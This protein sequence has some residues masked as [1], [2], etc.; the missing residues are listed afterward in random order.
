[1]PTRLLISLALACLCAGA[2]RAAD[3]FATDWAASGK[4]QAR[5]IAGG[6]RQAGFEI[7][8]APGAITYWRNPGDAGAP[9]AFD[10]SGSTNLARAEVRYPAPKRI[11]EP[12][13]SEAFGY[14]DAVVFAIDVEAA[15]PS[16]PVRL[17][18]KAGYAVCEK[19]CLPAK[20]NLALSLPEDGAS[21]YAAPIAAAR[22]LTPKNLAWAALGGEIFALDADN[23]RLCL[24]AEPG[25]ARDLFLEAPSGWW[26]SDKAE[27]KTAGR[28]CFAIALQQKPAD[29]AFPVAVRATFTGG[30]GPI[31]TELSLAP[32]S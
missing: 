16:K 24:P 13:G 30:A 28:D 1:M 27:A 23:W 12:D 5:L 20:A 8:L 22:A 6:P 26:L 7:E 32:K 18:V 14:D 2:A 31:D 3:A 29:G 17:A 11:A 19:I 21:P 4:A 10:F 9:P 15:D 25:P